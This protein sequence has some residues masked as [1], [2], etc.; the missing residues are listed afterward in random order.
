M[1]KDCYGVFSMIELVGSSKI[2]W[3]IIYYCYLFVCM[4]VGWLWVYIVVFECNFGNVFFN[5]FNGYWRLID[6]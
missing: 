1:F 6:F 3:V 4:I 5:V 2:G